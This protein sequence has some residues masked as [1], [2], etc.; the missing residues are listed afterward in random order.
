MV[1][2]ELELKDFRNYQSLKIQFDRG[3]N[4]VH[5]R[6]GQGKTNLVEALYLLTHLRSFRSPKLKTLIRQNQESAL[7]K[8]VLEKKGVEH[9]ARIS[10][11]DNQKRVILDEKNLQLSSEYIRGFF[12][13]LFAPDLLSAYKEYPNEKR[14]FYDRILIFLDPGY[15]IKLQEFNRIR[16]QKNLVLKSRNLSQLSSWNQLLS[17]CV[18]HLIQSRTK[19]IEEVN[20]L[21]SGIFQRLT[22]RQEEL[23]AH[24]RSDLAQ[25][26]DLTSESIRSFYEEKRENELQMGYLFYGPQKDSFWMTIEGKN[27]RQILS[28]GEQRVAFLSLL[29]ALNQLIERNL[30]FRP[31]LL[32]DDLFSELDEEVFS[33]T[34]EYLKGLQ[35]QIFITSTELPGS[36]RGGF[37]A[38]RVIQ[39]EVNQT[40]PT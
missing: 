29:F 7:I 40:T 8:A 13:L 37:S 24:Y 20:E 30:N 17:Q 2:P 18:P 33:H 6:N 38:F 32:L 21:L 22:G 35:N 10:L 12:S 3:V 5:G 23:K 14:A 19:L 11:I 27:D 25:K 36:N 26:T 28:Q 34:M 4:Y 31:L 16:K 39:G 9:Q 1:I 15:L